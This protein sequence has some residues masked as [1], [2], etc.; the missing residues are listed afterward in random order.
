MNACI[1]VLF[2]VLKGHFVAFVCTKLG[3]DKPMDTPSDF[4]S[5][6]NREK[7]L[8]YI[9]KLAQQVVDNFSIHSDA[10]LGAEVT[11]STDQVYSYGR[12]FCHFG[13]MVL[14]FH[15]AWREGDG[16][17]ICRCWKIFLLLFHCYKH[18]KYAWEALK[19]QFQLAS[20]PPSLAY[21]VKWGRFVNTRGG[22]GNNI[23]CDLFNEHL[24]KLFK[25]IIQNMD[26]NLTDKAMK[27]AARSVS[28]LHEFIRIFDEQTHIPATSSA[29]T[30]RSDED[31]VT[32]VVSVLLK[33]R[34]ME[35]KSGRK[36]SLFTNLEVNH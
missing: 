19:L 16:E 24:N 6:T 18:T 35:E 22:K 3:I 27:R 14:E 30:S 10:I 12:L 36:H 20:L 5:L 4:P 28:A 11:Q 2:T 25:E 26:P 34:I 13:S 29:H 33:N 32:Q 21:Q 1:D 17:R 15:D 31:D 8:S 23:P 7:K 9:I